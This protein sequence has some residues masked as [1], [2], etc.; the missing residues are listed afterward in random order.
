MAG[1]F[2]TSWSLVKA[3][4][5]VLKNDREL[6]LFPLFSTLS[7]L[8]VVVSFVGPLWTTGAL[9]HLHDAAARSGGSAFGV[10]GYA[11]LF[12]FYLC[13]YTVIFFFNTALV[14]VAMAR[15]QGDDA[16]LGDGLRLAWSRLPA[17]IGYALIAATV[18]VL[19]RALE[20]RAGLVGRWIIGLLGVAWTVATFLVVPVL[21]ATDLG[22]AA[23]VKESARLLRR[24]WGENLIGNAGIG[25]VFSVVM[26]AV[27]LLAGVMFVAAGAHSFAVDALVAGVFVLLFIVLALVQSTLQGIYSAALYR[28]ATTGE[29]GSG[30]ESTALQQAF[31]IKA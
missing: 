22:P 19:L 30:F 14:S 17:I 13:Q 23:A 31:R 1:K 24:S 27:A 15:L 2:A 3:S 26:V 5:V 11:L 7:T 21:A 29:A 6:L 20:R 8:L 25:I 10:G 28:Y 18:G 16:G 12:L 9:A 4:A